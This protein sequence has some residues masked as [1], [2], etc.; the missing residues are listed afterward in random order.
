M[1]D[2]LWNGAGG[3][4]LQWQKEGGREGKGH[5]LQT[6]G[7]DTTSQRRSHQSGAAWINNHWGAEKG[8]VQLTAGTH[9]SHD[10]M[11]YHLQLIRAHLHFLTKPLGQIIFTSIRF[12]A[13]SHIHISNM[14]VHCVTILHLLGC[15]KLLIRYVRVSKAA[16]SLHFRS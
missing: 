13:E 7:G 11:T 5:L 2:W 1:Q 15:T 10:L 12:L 3:C 6:E 9:R 8:Q 16:E 14:V 4:H